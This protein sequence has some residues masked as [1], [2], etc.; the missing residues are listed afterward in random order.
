MVPEFAE[1]D[2]SDKLYARRAHR[3]V[4]YQFITRLPSAPDQP[5]VH[6][7]SALAAGATP[8]DLFIAPF[9]RESAGDDC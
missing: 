4:T 2:E 9:E 5:C 3:R 6:K 7:P 1:A 8:G